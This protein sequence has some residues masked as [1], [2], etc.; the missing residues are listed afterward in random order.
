MQCEVD[1]Q[2]D[3]MTVQ[4]K[5]AGVDGILVVDSRVFDM[6]TK[7][8]FLFKSFLPLIEKTV[9]GNLDK[10]LADAKQNTPS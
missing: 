9:Q 1:R 6:K 2:A 8:V 7:L 4:F 5:R 3:K 10:A